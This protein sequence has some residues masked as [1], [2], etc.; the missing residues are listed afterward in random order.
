MKNILYK[1]LLAIV[2]IIAGNCIYAQNG[3]FTISFD[4]KDF[5]LERS[6]KYTHIEMEMPGMYYKD[7]PGKPALPY[8]PVNFAVPY[9]SK[10]KEL[11]I[12]YDTVLIADNI[13]ILPMQPMIPIGPKIKEQ[14]KVGPD[15]EIYRSSEPYPFKQVTYTSSQL[16]SCYQFF[17]F[18]ISPFI[19]LPLQKKLYL[20]TDITVNVS[21]TPGSGPQNSNRYDDGT[22]YNIL[23]QEVVNPENLEPGI[24]DNDKAGRCEYLI[25]TSDS[26]KDSFRP[27]ADWKIQKGIPT[28][29]VTVE[30]IYSNYDGE[31]KQ[32][33]IKKCILDYYQNK[34]TVFVL[35]GGDID[36]VPVQR[37]Y[38]FAGDGDNTIPTD[39][40][41]ACF[42][43]TF[44][45]DANNNKIYGEISD[46]VDI[47]PEVLITRAPVQTPSH[48]S[49][50]V[51]K[52]L[53]YEQ[54]PPQTGFANEMVNFG[55]QLF[56]SYNG[57]N[58]AAWLT[59]RMF[60]DYVDPYWNGVHH[61]FY[62]MDSTG[63]SYNISD[64]LVTSEINKGYNFIFMASHGFPDNWRTPVAPFFD[65][66]D[67]YEV[68]NFD[69]QGI[70]VTIACLTNAFDNFLWN[71]IQ[72]SW[73]EKYDS[74]F[75]ES[76]IRNPNG[77]AVA[78][79]GSSR[80][81]IALAEPISDLGPS[82]LYSANLFRSL[83]SGQPY[84]NKY[85]LGA[86]ATQTK[87]HLIGPSM[88][89]G[90]YRWLQ[91]ALN[92]L[93]DAALDIYTSDPV[94]ITIDCPDTIPLGNNQAITIK[95]GTPFSEICIQNT[96]DLYI[97]G[98]ANASGDFYCTPSP[99][100]YSP[101]V[102]TVTGH[103]AIYQAD[104]IRVG[105]P[106]GAVVILDNYTV[107]AG[108]D[109]DIEYCE[110]VEVQVT[111][112]NIGSDTA[113]NTSAAFFCN[114]DLIQINSGT[115]QAGDIPP[116]ES[117]TFTNALSFDVSCYVPDKHLFYPEAQISCNT[118]SWKS[119]LQFMAYAPDL[120]VEHISVESGHFHTVRSNDS[121]DIIID[122][123]NRG[124]AD[125]SNVETFLTSDGGSYILIYDFMD[126]SNTINAGEFATLR[127]GVYNQE[128]VG[129]EIVFVHEMNADH[130]TKVDAFNLQVIDSLE[131]FKTGDYTFYPWNLTQG[132][133]EWV[134]DSANNAFYGRFCARS[135]K[136]SRNQSSVLQLKIEILQDGFI[137]FYKKTS[138][139]NGLNNILSFS[140]DSIEQKSWPG[141]IEWSKEVFPVTTGIHTFTWKYHKVVPAIID[142]ADC[143]W[144][145]YIALPDFNLTPSAVDE[146][147]VLENDLT[148]FPNPNDGTFNIMFNRENPDYAIVRIFNIQGQLL[149]DE[150][151]SGST[152]NSI[153][154]IKSGQLSKGIYIIKVSDNKSVRTRKIIVQ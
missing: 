27:L 63:I 40:Y 86:I 41:Y 68:N 107:T 16:M 60:D 102:V 65:I 62:A 106:E 80:F 98:E 52:T 11:T 89:D 3:S 136:L 29:I 54:N 104:T 42:D 9:G 134:I 76:F 81:G 61:S 135:G 101:I 22:F 21:Y 137:S 6:D 4:K 58:D 73:P 141:F 12:S 152:K 116:G 79:H 8:L 138:D 151:F 97:T 71:N 55:I 117:K 112:K 126:T 119:T 144:I 148:I 114:D 109:Q 75:S 20:A 85:K 145:D 139:I 124:G 118:S 70:V 23:K 154:Q 1:I 95:T 50:F 130:Y 5:Q 18:D 83:F 94:A 10:F 19:Y 36:I 44:N 66:E 121:T 91:F 17:T 129:N 56:Q 100:T 25:V 111:L 108:D 123:R 149:Y 122:I 49:V 2:F 67:A 115:V 103:N 45:W 34:G 53:N 47:A 88:Q 113:F 120:C 74:C 105:E 99:L 132:D 125:A 28:E 15:K 127:Y 24:R 150:K 26:L 128:T 33:K 51:N 31:S 82:F 78:Y 13:D 43:G 142:T 48:T 72:T 143:V 37:C 77:G 84:N 57:R 64:S 147:M 7:S 90:S 146:Q 30:D 92:T 133:S 39:L 46:N 32:V 38:A 59:D 69:Q 93:G 110:N 14:K 140:I 87:I 153:I 131:Y 35:L 96:D